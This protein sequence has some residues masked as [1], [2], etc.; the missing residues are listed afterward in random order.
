M[1]A[2]SLDL[3]Q[4]VVEA[5]KTGTLTIK[6]V[7]AQFRVGET[8]VKKMLRCERETGAVKAYVQGG[9]RRR[10]LTNRQMQKLKRLVENEP[11]LTL[12]ELREKLLSEEP[13]QVSIATL[14]RVLTEIGLPRKKNRHSHKSETTTNEPGIGGE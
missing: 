5:Y 2:Y 8:F 1:K 13:V 9:G 10:A 4:R 14:S 7:A 11:D 3:R 6:A 12:V